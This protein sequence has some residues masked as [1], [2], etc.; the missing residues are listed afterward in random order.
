MPRQASEIRRWGK[1]R[2]DVI[3]SQGTSRIVAL[4]RE[5]RSIPIAFVVVND[6][7]AHLEFSIVD[8]AIQV[9]EEIAPG[10]I[11]LDRAASSAQRHALS[12]GG[13]RR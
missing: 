6:P 3:L 9:L 5:A 8:T 12:R 1:A 7:V 10:A 13:R 2:R 4:N 11:A